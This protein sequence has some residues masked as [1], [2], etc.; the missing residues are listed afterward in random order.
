MAR[1]NFFLIN[2]GPRSIFSL[3]CGPRYIWV[4]TFVFETPKW[5]KWNRIYILIVFVTIQMIRTTVA[6][7][8]GFPTSRRR[9]LRRT[10]RP[11]GLRPRK[12]FPCQATELEHSVSLIRTSG[13]SHREATTKLEWFQVGLQS[14]MSLKIW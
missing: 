10:R 2:C 13:T 3:E 7:E 4:D 11:W 1:K 12:S 6:W 5:S 8:L 9:K 14:V